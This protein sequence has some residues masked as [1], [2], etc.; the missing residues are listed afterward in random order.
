MSFRPVQWVLV[1]LYNKSAHRATYGRLPGTTYTKDY[2]QL[3]RTE[4]F[5]ST[6]RAAIPIGPEGSATVPLNYVWPSGTQRGDFI[7]LSADRPHL[8]WDTASGAPPPWKLGPEPTPF[9]AHTLPGDPDLSTSEE[10]DAEFD[11][12]IDRCGGQPYL[13]AVKLRDEKQ[14]LHL[15]VYIDDPNSDFAWASTKSLPLPVLTL[16]SSTSRNVGSKA[17]LFE[18]RGQAPDAC[19]MRALDALV[20]SAEPRRTLEE[21]DRATQTQ[22]SHYCAA[23]ALGIFFD[24]ERNHDAWLDSAPAQHISSRLDPS[25][26][27]VIEALSGTAGISDHAAEALP[28]EMSAI[29]QF[30]AQMSAGSYMVADSLATMKVRGSAQRVFATAVKS[31]YEQ[32][33]AITGITSKELLVAAHIVPW[34]EDETIR[35]D[36]SN[37]ICLSPIVDR[38]FELGFLEIDAV[39]TVN[40]RLDRIA[41]DE[42]L[43]S[44][45]LQFQGTKIRAPLRHPPDPAYLVRRALLV[46]RRFPTSDA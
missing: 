12:L 24:P 29:E 43:A 37:G 38:A 19:V 31:N 9:T 1:V 28:V 34:S 41:Q 11:R 13:V 26:F 25:L 40:V 39:L 16:I 27:A 2:I 22:L 30:D 10:A 17:A 42:Q 35:L 20:S 23:P 18:S 14:A 6:A 15:R 46:A 32:T 45:L 21:F 8:K 33:C 44:Y 5:L 4:Q 3:S 36:P 7:Y